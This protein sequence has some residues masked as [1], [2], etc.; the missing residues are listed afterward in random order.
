MRRRRDTVV[1]PF[2]RSGEVWSDM[3]ERLT[4]IAAIE[5]QFDCGVNSFDDR[6]VLQKVVYLLETLGMKLGYRYN[7]YIH[8]PYSPA[9]ASDAYALGMGGS[10]GSAPSESFGQEEDAAIRAVKHALE[11][12]A[13]E[14]RV[15]WL[16]ALASLHWIGK[17]VSWDRTKALDQFNQDKVHLQNMGR[18]ALKALEDMGAWLRVR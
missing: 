12:H 14:D 11:E 5:K 7:W 9:L 2:N 15:Q 4:K 8:G 17:G 16:E 13:D 1:G 3:R 10:S 6:L 18:E